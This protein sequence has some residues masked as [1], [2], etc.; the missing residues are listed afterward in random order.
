MSKIKETQRLAE[1]IKRLTPFFLAELQSDSPDILIRGVRTVGMFKIREGVPRL[2]NLLRNENPQIRAY[3]AGALLSIRDETSV[4]AL[5]EALKDSNAEVRKHAVEA[6]GRMRQKSALPEMLPLLQD[7]APSV[8]IAAM[9]A[10]ASFD[11]PEIYPRL[12]EAIWDNDI[13]VVRAAIYEVGAKF[14]C[15]KGNPRA[16]KDVVP[17]VIQLMQGKNRS[18]GYRR[19]ALKILVAVKDVRAFSE[20]Y[21]AFKTWKVED[22][23]F[24]NKDRLVV[25]M[26]TFIAEL[27]SDDQKEEAI[28]WLKKVSTKNRN[29]YNRR[30]AAEALKELGVTEE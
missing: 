12:V 5:R 27:G 13:K 26:A 23:L 3:A 28:E 9:Y 20:I 7:I 18:D 14:E 30:Y 21:N 6:L 19:R 17:R 25:K 2:E 22:G 24:T 10:V 8:R 16:H 29:E 15:G 1:E 4:P 11:E